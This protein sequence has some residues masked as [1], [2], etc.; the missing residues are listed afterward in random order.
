MVMPSTRPATL[1]LPSSGEATASWR[2]SRQGVASD[3]IDN[4]YW[5]LYR[6]AFLSS[7]D[8]PVVSLEPKALRYRLNEGPD[9]SLYHYICL[10]PQFG[11][12]SMP[13]HVPHI[14]LFYK[15]TFESGETMYR[16]YFAALKLL[17][18]RSLPIRLVP[19][20]TAN[21]GVQEGSELFFLLKEMQR[22]IL[23]HSLSAEPSEDLHITWVDI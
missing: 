15:C 5:H 12:Y 8:C 7:S 13:L 4:E 20:G 11:M 23:K 19:R 1:P 2:R 17:L 3:H 18:P 16:S 21:F 14:T 6:E 10:F 22:K 9:G